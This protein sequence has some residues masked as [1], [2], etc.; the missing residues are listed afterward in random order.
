[1]LY[2]D[3]VSI[4]PT[5]HQICSSGF[6]DGRLFSLLV[7]EFNVYGHG[8]AWIFKSKNY[9]QLLTTFCELANEIATYQLNNFLAQTSVTTYVLDETSF[10]DQL[11]TTIN[12]F[13]ES[14]VTSFRLYIDTTRLLLQADQPLIASAD[15]NVILNAEFNIY[16]DT[17]QSSIPVG[18]LWLTAE[19]SVVLSLVYISSE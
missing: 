7:S 5:F 10:N 1:M 15:S 19:S 8:N 16:G 18:F 2:G 14:M 9:F 11:N 3:F 17:S 6:V 13:L 4:S 12:Q